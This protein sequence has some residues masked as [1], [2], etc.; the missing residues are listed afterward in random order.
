MLRNRR[1]SERQ[2]VSQI[3]CTIV[4][5][6]VPA[7]GV[8]LDL[9]NEGAKVSGIRVS[10][11]F[12]DQVVQVQTQDEA[13]IAQCRTVSRNQ[14][15]TFQIGLLRVNEQL[16]IPSP[17]V[18]INSFVQNGDLSSVCLPLGFEGNS[19][20]VQLL[21]GQQ[22]TLP[23]HQVVQLTRPERLEKLCDE[24]CL[25]NALG[26]YGHPS[27]GNDFGDRTTVLNHEFGP[28]NLTPVAH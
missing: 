8:I 16:P 4:I 7:E 12:A 3:P 24:D 15:G 19:I 18:L 1:K 14:D 6:S 20:R 28:P 27:S 5:N 17:T 22:V 9:S 23:Q 26:A 25:E 2:P 11:L 10:L 21:D 13:F